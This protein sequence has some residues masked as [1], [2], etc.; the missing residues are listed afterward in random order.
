MWIT[1]DVI[2]IFGTD[3]MFFDK[4]KNSFER[5]VRGAACRKFFCWRSLLNLITGAQ[6]FGQ[7]LPIYL[8]FEAKNVGYAL[9]HLENWLRASRGAAIIRVHPYFS[10]SGIFCSA[11]SETEGRTAKT[12][13]ATHRSVLLKVL[14]CTLIS[15]MYPEILRAGW[16]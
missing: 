9:G 5:T 4:V 13:M 8:A 15:L 12:E 6:V 16:G 2:H 14:V 3:A 11:F 10:F 7:G 1:F